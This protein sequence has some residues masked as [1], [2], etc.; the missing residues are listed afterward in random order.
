[1]GLIAQ[2]LKTVVEGGDHNLLQSKRKAITTLLPYAI[3]QERDGRPE[4]LDTFLRAVRASEE[5]AFTWHHIGKYG[6]ALLHEATPHATVSLLPYI[7]WDWLTNRKDMI[8]RWVAA[9][10]AVPY[11]NEAAQNVVNTLLQIASK[12][13]LLPHIPINVWLWLTKRPLLPPICSGRYV[14][15]C[16]HVVKAVRALKDIE[17]LKSYFLLVW[18]EW[19]IPG[20]PP[21]HIPNRI[22]PN[23][24]SAN[25]SSTGSTSIRRSPYFPDNMPIIPLSRT[26]SSTP[27]VLPP[28]TL[29]STSGSRSSASPNRTS[30]YPQFQRSA[31][32]SPAPHPQQHVGLP[33]VLH[34]PIRPPSYVPDRT[35]SI[36]SSTSFHSALIRPSSTSSN[37]SWV[38]TD[39]SLPNSHTPSIPSCHI[40]F[41]PDSSYLSGSFYD[42]EISIQED[43]GGIG[44][45]HHRADLLQRLDHVLGQLDRGLEY[46]KQHNPAFNEDYLQRMKDR[47]QSLSETLLETNVKAISRTSHSMIKSSSLS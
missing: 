10:S 28:H 33:P 26:P 4:L 35:S 36:H 11:T 13:E 3:W 24:M 31:G 1:V 44:M 43:F 7:P 41:I 6:S 39:A 21:P 2:N 30:S 20:R 18:S 23:W 5:W 46:L 17:I 32:S 27:I 22:I 34:A 45:G 37:S 16:A 47:Y 42:M 38:L 29:S 15:T 14:G 8:Q 12:E 40:P 9:A 25:S 19:N